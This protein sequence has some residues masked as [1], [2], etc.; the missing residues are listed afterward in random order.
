MARYQF[1]LWKLVARTMEDFLFVSQAGYT[2]ARELIFSSESWLD[3]VNFL[4]QRGG[5]Y[6]LAEGPDS[7]IF[8]LKNSLYELVS[9][10]VPQ[11]DMC[12]VLVMRESSQGI[13]EIGYFPNRMI[14]L[15]YISKLGSPEV[16]NSDSNV[17][18]GKVGNEIYCIAADIS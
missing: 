2:P 13:V 11:F 10:E 8:A 4:K 6:D 7:T 3:C 17:W 9:E 15:E 12:E 18:Y 1:K 14:A 5:W 16:I